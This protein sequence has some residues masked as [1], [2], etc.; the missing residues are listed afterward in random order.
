MAGDTV[1]TER[2]ARKE[3]RALEAPLSVKHELSIRRRGRLEFSDKTS[4]AENGEFSL[5]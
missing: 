5:H 1:E 2:A 3:C 4:G